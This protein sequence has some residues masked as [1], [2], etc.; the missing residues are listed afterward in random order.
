MYTKLVSFN[1]M[2]NLIANI[3]LIKDK[4]IHVLRIR[5]ETRNYPCISAYTTK[6]GRCM[7]GE[8]SRQLS[9]ECRTEKL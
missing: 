4:I 7:E 3:N 6:R 5:Y 8:G 1:L 2:L 9:K